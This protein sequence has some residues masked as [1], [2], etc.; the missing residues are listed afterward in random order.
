MLSA[1][2][3][4]SENVGGLMSELL[5]RVVSDVGVDRDIAEKAVGIILAFMSS[6]GPADRVVSLLAR[7]P[8][9]QALTSAVAREGSMLGSMGGIMGVGAKLMGIGLGMS[10]IQSV[11]RT[12]ASYCNEKGGGDDLKAIAAAIPGLSQFM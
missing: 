2:S 11:V 9:H 6:E 10:Q 7:L 12:M 4:Q 8:D 5:A 3:P 1:N